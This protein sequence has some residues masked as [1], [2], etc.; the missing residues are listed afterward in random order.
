MPS[1]MK[2]Q[3]QVTNIPKTPQVI[4]F[5]AA[6]G[7]V[8]LGFLKNLI[9]CWCILIATANIYVFIMHKHHFDVMAKALKWFD[10]EGGALRKAHQT[11]GT[12]PQTIFSSVG[13]VWE[14]F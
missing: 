4:Y 14:Q 6:P 5:S 11:L 10:A 13:L 7:K 9:W 12:P 1:N 8:N 2:H 3:F